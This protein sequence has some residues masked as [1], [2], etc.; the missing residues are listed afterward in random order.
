[1]AK[2]SSKDKVKDKY[3]NFVIKTNYGYYVS[4]VSWHNLKPVYSE[5]I[6]DANVFNS[7]IVCGWYMDELKD[8]E[9]SIVDLNK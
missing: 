3:G 9:K 2:K 6:N 8:V 1:M 5:N 7:F 4:T